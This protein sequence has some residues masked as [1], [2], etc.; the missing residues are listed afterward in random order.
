MLKCVTNLH[1]AEGDAVSDDA[2]IYYKLQW[3]VSRWFIVSTRGAAH[4]VCICK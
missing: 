2:S 1:L 3:A 4:F